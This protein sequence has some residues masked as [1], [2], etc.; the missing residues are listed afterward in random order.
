MGVII[1]VTAHE[2]VVKQNELYKAKYRAQSIYSASAA[3]SLPSCP[4]L[5]D[6]IDGSPPGSTVPGQMLAIIATIQVQ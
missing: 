6:P 5:C 3:K 2:V 1:A 4:T